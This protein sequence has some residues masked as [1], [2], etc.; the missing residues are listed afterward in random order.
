MSYYDSSNKIRRRKVNSSN[1]HKNSIDSDIVISRYKQENNK[2]NTLT[3]TNDGGFF[4]GGYVEGNAIT[5]SYAN[6]IKYNSEG[7]EE[8][9]KEIKSDNTSIYIDELKQTQDEGTLIVGRAQGDVVLDDKNVLECGKGDWDP[10]VIKYSKGQEIEWVNSF[11]GTSDDRIKTILETSDGSILVGGYFQSASIELGNNI[12]L[13]RAEAGDQWGM[14]IKYDNNGNIQWAKNT[15]GRFDEINKII[16]TSDNKYMVSGY[17]AGEYELEGNLI[18]SHNDY[19]SG[20]INMIPK[21]ML[22][23]LKH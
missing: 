18:G 1:S 13:K 7:E 15:Q 21:V 23:L 10:F 8:Y 4:V 16:E 20:I 3:E 2:I 12:I 5:S 14:L 11:G 22:N 6:I 9:S 19:F 17:V